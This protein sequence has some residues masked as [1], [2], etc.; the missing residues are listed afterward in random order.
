MRVMLL[1]TPFPSHFSPMIPLAWA[2][3]A[4][5]HEVRVVAQPDVVDLAHEAGLCTATVGE[6]YYAFDN[7]R[8]LAR[9]GG[10]GG[11]A[12]GR[13]ASPASSAMLWYFHAGYLLPRYLE[14][15][16]SWRPDLIVSEQFEL[17]GTIIAAVLGIPSIRHRWGIDPLSDTIRAVSKTALLAACLR[18]GLDGLPEPTLLLDPCPP[19]LQIP[20][21]TPGL[22]IRHVPYNGPGGVP[23]WLDDRRADRRVCVSLGRWTLKLGGIPLLRGI[24]EAFD[25][26]DEVEA[27]VTADAESAAEL[28]PVPKSVRVVPPTPLHLFLDGCDAVVH[29]CGANTAMTVAGSGKPQVILP[30]LG[31]EYAAA[32]RVAAVEAAVTIEDGDRQR[33]PAV[34]RAALDQV[35][36]D[37]RHAKA[38]AAIG[39]EMAAM[40]SPALVVTDLATALR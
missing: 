21:V 7:V 18:H 40:P 16:R 25:G 2:L 8:A 5:G 35:L 28:G 27:V 36:A 24:C 22:P 6:R 39:A 1:S 12:S 23:E 13:T 19:T 26:M 11:A 37:P 4:A 32:N 33:D 34:L 10:L 15:A 20:G 31:D 17:T 38:A 29:H 3:R 9:A 30:Q 14:F